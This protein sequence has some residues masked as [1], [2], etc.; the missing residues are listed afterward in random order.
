MLIGESHRSDDMVL[1]ARYILQA[2]DWEPLVYTNL[3]HREIRMRPNGEW[4]CPTCAY[5]VVLV[6]YPKAPDFGALSEAGLRSQNMILSLYSYTPTL[7]CPAWSAS[8]FEGNQ[9]H[10]DHFPSTRLIL[11][12]NSNRRTNSW[13]YLNSKSNCYRYS[14][15]CWFAMKYGI[16]FI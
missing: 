3:L 14:K 12:P 1:W 15:Y 6:L 10:Q 7:K 4:G 9:S 5:G 13:F 2:G 8:E 16:D 11:W